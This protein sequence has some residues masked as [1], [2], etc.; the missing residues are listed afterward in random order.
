MMR[1][2]LKAW[3]VIPLT[4]ALLAGAQIRLAQVRNDLSLQMQQL[5]S[6]QQALRQES[7]KLRL[8]VASLSRPERLRRY[9]ITTLHMGPPTPMQ[10]IHQ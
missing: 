2:G 1:G 7:S 3:M 6:E 10:V 4:L 5:Q 8:E 9:A